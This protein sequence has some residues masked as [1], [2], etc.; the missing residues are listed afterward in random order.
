MKKVKLAATAA[1]TAALAAILLPAPAAS[2]SQV[3]CGDPNF[4]DVSWHPS[5]NSWPH[6]TCFA[7]AGWNYFYGAPSE[8]S[9]MDGIHTGNNDVAVRDCNGALVDVPRGSDI[10]F[11]TARCLRDVGIK[12]F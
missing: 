7:G 2:A 5:D 10:W 6:N 12:P 3:P 1:A 4:V 9:W 11:R 8:T